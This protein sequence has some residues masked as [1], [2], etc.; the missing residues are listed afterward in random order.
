M[1]TTKIERA[2]EA[3]MDAQKEDKKASAAYSTWLARYTPAQNRLQRHFDRM[4][5][6]GIAQLG[7]KL[8]APPWPHDLGKQSAK[9]LL[10]RF[11]E[12]N[13]MEVVVEAAGGTSAVATSSGY[14]P[15]TIR[16]WLRLPAGKL[17]VY[18]IVAIEK[19]SGLSANLSWNLYAAQSDREKER[20]PRKRAA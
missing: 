10:R 1:A 19:A 9:T 8:P 17:K 18:Q 12:L 11:P 13:W 16:R 14:R 3:L 15:A 5:E 6:R 2:I 7:R 4:K 20:R